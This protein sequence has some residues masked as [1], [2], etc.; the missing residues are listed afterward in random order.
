MNVYIVLDENHFEIICVCKD[1]MD[2][3]QIAK[4]HDYINEEFGSRCVVITE[5]IV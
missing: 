4:K 1:L 5:K 2:A 3:Y